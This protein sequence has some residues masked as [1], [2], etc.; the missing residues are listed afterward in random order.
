MPKHCPSVQHG[1]HIRMQAASSDRRIL[2][3]GDPF[4][5]VQIETSIGHP[6]QGGVPWAG[7]DQARLPELSDQRVPTGR[8]PQGGGGDH[9]VD[10]AERRALRTSE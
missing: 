8:V 6:D 9:A 5:D 2:M 3:A 1:V 7:A 10:N 4:Q